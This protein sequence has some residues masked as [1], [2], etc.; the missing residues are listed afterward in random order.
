M[1][2]GHSAVGSPVHS[3]AMASS[4]PPI[5]NR[6]EAFKDLLIDISQ[7]MDRENVNR[8]AF[9]AGCNLPDTTS[10]LEVL[11]ELRRQGVVSPR[12]CTTLKT[13]LRK[14]GRYDLGDLVQEYMDD[15]P[16]PPSGKSEMQSSV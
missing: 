11:K 3:E 13:L 1:D 14:I 4:E 6:E 16:D 8:L 9:R 5:V 15:F 2:D 7:K 10:P 12:S